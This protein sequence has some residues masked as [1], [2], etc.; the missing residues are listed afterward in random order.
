MGSRAIFAIGLALSFPMTSGTMEKAEPPKEPRAVRLGD[1]FSLRVGEA[2][3]VE[4]ADV[5]VTFQQVESDSRCPKDVNCI[6]AGE[7]VVL[8]ALARAGRS[9]VLELEVPPGGSSAASSFESLL[10]TVV[11]LEPQKDS[12]KSI[13][14]SAYVATVKISPA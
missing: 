5:T 6:R 12:R 1:S 11:E 8:L 9:A 14:P 3:N 4:D 10:V 13:D 7:A 2:A